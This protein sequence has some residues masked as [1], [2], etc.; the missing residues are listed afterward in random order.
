MPGIYEYDRAPSGHVSRKPP[1]GNFFSGGNRG[2]HLFFVLSG[3]IIATVHAGD[4]GRPDRVSNY[5]FNRVTRIYPAVWIMTVLALVL[6]DASFGGSEKVSKLQP[7][8]VAASFLLLPQSGDA[9]VNVTWT[10]KY[11]IAFYALFAVTIASRWLG[12]LVIGL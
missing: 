6:Y 11:E 4:I 8:S 3:F 12:L 7:W 10:L 5:L 9:L 1:L 2:I